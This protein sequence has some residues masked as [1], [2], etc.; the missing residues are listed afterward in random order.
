MKK[1]E[2]ALVDKKEYWEKSWPTVFN[3]YFWRRRQHMLMVSEYL[4]VPVLD[5]GCGPGYLA[6]L[7]KPNEAHY[8]GVDISKEAVEH[9]KMLFP[10]AN[11]KVADATKGLPYGNGEFEMVT[12]CEFLEHIEDYHGVIE[13]MKRVS[14]S[15]VI[16][17]VP[18]KLPNPDHVWPQWDYKDIESEFGKHGRILE[19]R[20]VHEYNFN[21]VR[22]I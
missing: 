8:T 3:R 5:V 17:T 14:R 4:R 2:K 21:I 15:E 7:I 16:V 10:A 20:R 12:A 11:F 18:I 1:N 13:E 19:I 22:I 9:G 6:G